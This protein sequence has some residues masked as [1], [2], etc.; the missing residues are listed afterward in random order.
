M[1]EVFAVTITIVLPTLPTLVNG[2]VA[3][4]GAYSQDGTDIHSGEARSTLI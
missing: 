3:S 1:N 4:T 2:E